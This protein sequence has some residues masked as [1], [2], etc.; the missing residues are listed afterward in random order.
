MRSMRHYKYVGRDP[1]LVGQAAWG[2]RV[3]SVFKV[4]IDWIGHTWSHGWHDAIRKDWRL[5]KV[6]KVIGV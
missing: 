2:M 1:S 5:T 6:E 4:Q 3:N